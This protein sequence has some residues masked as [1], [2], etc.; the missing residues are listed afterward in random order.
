MLVSE[1]ENNV[2]SVTALAAGRSPGAVCGLEQRAQGHGLAGWA[3][4][5]VWV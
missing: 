3:D 2:I 4:G 1:P 5:R